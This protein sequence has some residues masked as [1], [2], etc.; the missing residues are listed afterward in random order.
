PAV[1][2]RL[3]EGERMLTLYHWEP[4]ANSGKPMR[5]LAEKGSDYQSHYLDL[6]RFDQHQPACLRINPDGTI[7]ALVHGDRVLTESTPMMD[8]IDEE[9]PGHRS[10]RRQRWS[11]GVCG[12]RRGRRWLRGSNCWSAHEQPDRAV[13]LGTQHPLPQAADRAARA[14]S[15]AS[16]SLQP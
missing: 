4:N 7:P 16:I 14:S 2:C 12:R 15:L 9:F 3:A 6:L 11:A 5:T 10:S 1:R 8:Y 13:S